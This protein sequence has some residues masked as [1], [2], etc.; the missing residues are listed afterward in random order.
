MIP[1]PETT[2]RRRAE[3]FYVIG[4]RGAA[5][6]APENTLAGFSKALEIGV[7]G[8]ELDVQL[9][10]D[11]IAVV[12][13]DFRLKPDITRTAEG[14]WLERGNR[15]PIKDLTLEELKRYDVGRLK[16]GTPYADRYP[17]QMPVDGERVPTLREVVLLLKGGEEDKTQLWI[18]IKTSPEEPEISQSPESVADAVVGILRKE[19][20]SARTMILSFDWRALVHVQKTA[21]EIPTVYLSPMGMYRTSFRPGQPGPSPWTAGFN[22]ADF[23]GSMPLAVK[24]A[25]G[26]YW[27]PNHMTIT[28]SLVQEAHG[29]GLKVFVWAPDSRHQ[30][31]RLMDMGVD[32]I[33]TNRPDML[34][35]IMHPTIGIRKS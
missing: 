16:P 8:V 24:A 9:S 1:S 27:A 7:D 20:F 10:A 32:G 23:D 13:H 17:D 19:E 5:G 26:R 30:M 14:E 11:G 29:L 18:E 31:R 21:P 15:L 3:D 28:S 2:D 34:K 33:M 25:G 6:L 22:V 35:S 4:H 12:Y